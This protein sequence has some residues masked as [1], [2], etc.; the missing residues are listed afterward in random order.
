MGVI[1]PLSSIISTA[2]GSIHGFSHFS[3]GRKMTTKT[4]L[5]TNRT[6][7]NPPIGH[8]RRF[9]GKA[10]SQAA[11]N[12]VLPSSAPPAQTARIYIIPLLASG[13]HKED[14]ISQSS[15][16]RTKVNDRLHCKLV[17]PEGF[18][19]SEQNSKRLLAFGIICKDGFT[20]LARI[21]QAQPNERL[22]NRR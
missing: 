4:L 13:G 20:R 9:P 8:T 17:I 15:I 19:Q 22:P 7:D 10:Q 3:V 2:S 21:G 16:G 6:F 12:L 18:M 5:T 14:G 11:E 1:F